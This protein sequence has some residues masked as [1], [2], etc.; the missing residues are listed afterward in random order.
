MLGLSEQRESWPGLVAMS[1]SEKSQLC[2]NSGVVAYLHVNSLERSA[3]GMAWLQGEIKAT[4]DVW[5][6]STVTF[7]LLL[8]LLGMSG[9]SMG[10]GTCCPSLMTWVFIPGAHI[11][12][13]RETY[14]N[15]VPW[16]L[17]ECCSMYAKHTHTRIILRNPLG[18]ATPRA[19]PGASITWG[20]VRNS[21][22]QAPAQTE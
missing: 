1:K 5:S 15:F 8:L 21:S 18:F 13:E 14:S 10:K 2:E 17:C 11:Q 4:R 3:R 16:P 20:L 19:D 12:V 22:S 6:N 7:G 9:S